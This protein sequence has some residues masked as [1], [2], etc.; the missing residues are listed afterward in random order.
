MMVCV[1][2][3]LAV[4]AVVAALLVACGCGGQRST[5][6]TGESEL[7][8]EMSVRDETNSE[9]LY[10]IDRAGWISFGGGFQ[11]RMGTTTWTGSLS[12]VERQEIA[13]VINQQGWFTSPIVSTNEPKDRVYRV[14]IDAPP[15]HRRFKVVGH[16]ERMD[17]VEQVLGRICLRRLDGELERLPEPGLQ[18]R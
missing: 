17:A 18:Q 15:G 8:L 9:R 10:K 13:D 12:D 2:R 7:L 6:L 5:E 11:A 3:W 16:N 14:D 4:V 1:C